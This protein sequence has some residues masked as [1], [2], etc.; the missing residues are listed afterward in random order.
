M[1]TQQP[2]LI[3]QSYITT[4]STSTAA[5]ES[6]APIV[7]PRSLAQI[8][9]SALAHGALLLALLAYDAAPSQR[10]V[11]REANQH[12]D[13]VQAAPAAA[14]TARSSE[15]VTAII[16]VFGLNRSQAADV[17]QVRRQSIYNWLGGAEAEG[18]NLNRMLRLYEMAN[19]VA[20]PIEPHLTVRS[21]PDG[22][23]SLLRMLST[24]PLDRT[25]IMAWVTALVQPSEIPW[26]Q[27]LE[28]ALREAGIP[29]N[30]ERESQRGA[31]GIRYLQG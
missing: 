6:T 8:G 2:L 3:A 1:T 17:M 25:A 10:N 11:I 16:K 26:P 19:A 23:N 15:M 21:T 20:Q 31:D 12:G 24:D 22:T 9:T 7:Q 5:V 14:P 28:D 30:A 18:E 4:A 27:P 13:K 29:R